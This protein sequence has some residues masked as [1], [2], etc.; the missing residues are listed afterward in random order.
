MTRDINIY[1][2]NFENDRLPNS[3]TIIVY[4]RPP[5]NVRGEKA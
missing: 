4:G 5:M 3:Q 2:T 1:R